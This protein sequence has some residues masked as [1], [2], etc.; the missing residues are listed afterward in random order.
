MPIMG[1]AVLE[2]DPLRPKIFVNITNLIAE[3]L[4][5][6]QPW[7]NILPQVL[8]ML[9]DVFEKVAYTGTEIP[10]L[11]LK[12]I[13]QL[14]YEPLDTF[15]NMRDLDLIN[16]A[17]EYQNLARERKRVVL[18]LKGY[19]KSEVIKNF[20]EY[21]QRYFSTITDPDL[22]SRVCSLLDE[23]LTYD[24]TGRGLAFQPDPEKA[25]LLLADK[26]CSNTA[27]TEEQKAIISRNIA[28]ALY[29]YRYSIYNNEP[30]SLGNSSILRE[31][32]TVLSQSRDANDQ[33]ISLLE[34]IKFGLGAKIYNKPRVIDYID[35]VDQLLQTYVA[36]GADSFFATLANNLQSMKDLELKIG[37]YIS[38]EDITEQKHNNLG[39]SI[40]AQL[41]K[42]GFTFEGL[43]QLSKALDL[44]LP[45][46]Y[47]TDLK[48]SDDFNELHNQI[49]EHLKNTNPQPVQD[50]AQNLQT[51]GSHQAQDLARHQTGVL[52]PKS[53]DAIA[54]KVTDIIAELERELVIYTT[55]PTKYQGYVGRLQI[56]KENNTAD[57]LIQLLEQVSH[58]LK[59][60]INQNPQLNSLV[61]IM[62]DGINKLKCISKDQN[63]ETKHKLLHTVYNFL[64]NIM[65][66][67]HDN[68]YAQKLLTVIKCIIRKCKELCHY[69]LGSSQE[70]S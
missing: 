14:Q 42:N 35:E 48:S 41:I 45:T 3:G 55:L 51:Q 5:I 20:Q 54:I 23:V 1:G 22:L 39:R 61:D 60:E 4:D 31:L 57:G 9:Q 68:Q 53:N 43:E 24:A 64:C 21:R 34:L 11:L 56:C 59:E 15:E 36:T 30:F 46:N 10:V 16:D 8:T 25:I 47:L 26:L 62:N 17:Q 28:Q 44:N 38:K 19:I 29:L 37:S 12:R 7:A 65:C 52:E 69:I 49:K 66:N 50:I 58:E 27:L 70:R 32:Q 18:Y 67:I 40:I 6:Q 63:P 2:E 33:I 13:G